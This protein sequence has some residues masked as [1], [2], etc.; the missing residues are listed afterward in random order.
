MLNWNPVLLNED[1]SKIKQPE[2]FKIKLFEHQK[3]IVQKMVEIETGNHIEYQEDE[4]HFQVN[5][6]L[7][8]LSDKLGAG[9][10]L[11]IL[12]LIAQDSH[13]PQ[14][15][16]IPTTY[17][18]EFFQIN[19]THLI[20]NQNNQNIPNKYNLII[21]K[22]LLIKQWETA[23]KNTNLKSYTINTSKCLEKIKF[24]NENTI[25]IEK[26]R[27]IQDKI[28]TYQ[29]NDIN[30]ILISDTFLKK[31]FV[32]KQYFKDIHW[33]RLIIDEPHTFTLPNWFKLNKNDFIWL[34]TATPNN[35]YN[36]RFFRGKYSGYSYFLNSISLLSVKN[37]DKYVD[38]SLMLQNPIVKIIKCYTPSYLSNLQKYIP[39]KALELI[40]AGNLK[41]A[42]DTLNCNPDTKSNIV[43][44]L[45]EFYKS[46]IKNIDAHLN[47]INSLCNITEAEKKERSKKDLLEKEKLQHKIKCIEDRLNEMNGNVCP[48]CIDTYTNPTVTNCCQN[49]FCL[50]CLLIANTHSYECPYC[51]SKLDINKIKPI[52]KNNVN[53][54]ENPNQLLKEKSKEPTKNEAIIDLLLK[55]NSSQKFLLFSKYY[56]SFNDI[57][58][59]FRKI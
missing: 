40:Q 7:G 8:I 52:I 44:S 38:Q 55:S 49:I 16:I 26:T 47:Y 41:D 57:I 21:V 3:T 56:N 31:T 37:D 29:D 12:A 13:P 23:I 48:I 20:N 27:K 10:T 45:T 9:K 59:K 46:K 6:K 39:S 15:Y 42:I 51:R 11:E 17:G 35:L 36:T 5:T 22:H 18:N 34:I 54:N 32:R 4:N 50:E 14:N 30:L 53:N 25:S 19:K 24:N 58:K 2:S 33:K 28:E 1:L 43:K